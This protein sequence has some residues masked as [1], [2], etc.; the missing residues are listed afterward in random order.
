MSSVAA[1]ILGLKPRM[2]E[3]PPELRSFGLRTACCECGCKLEDLKIETT[4]MGPIERVDY[5]INLA[6]LKEWPVDRQGSKVSVICPACWERQKS[7]EA[8]PL[9]AFAKVC[10]C[11]KCG[12]SDM[13]IRFCNGLKLCELRAV[14]DHLHRGCKRC[15]YSFV[16]A[17]KDE[18]VNVAP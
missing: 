13:T 4:K 6:V 9:P 5:L 1:K 16:Q 11:P 14:R 10:P 3:K 18:V 15:G 17:C 12:N 2:T 7:A 8:A